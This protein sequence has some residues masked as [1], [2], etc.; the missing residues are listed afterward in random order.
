LDIRLLEGGSGKASALKMSYGAL[1]KGL[2]AL[3]GGLLIAAQQ[4]G[5]G[6]A[7]AAEFSDS[8]QELLQWVTA[9]LPKMPPKAYRWVAEMEEVGKTCD[10]GGVPGTMF[11][12]AAEFYAF[13]ADSPLPGAA[14]ERAG[15]LTLDDVVTTLAAACQ[16]RV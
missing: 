10:T 3:A 11:R 4:N 8:Q 1:T 2:M 9:Q 12:G 16:V 5:V 6:A 14:R 13:V 15:R 7:L